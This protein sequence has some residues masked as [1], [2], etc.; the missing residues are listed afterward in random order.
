M[1]AKVGTGTLTFVKSIVYGFVS[2]ALMSCSGDFGSQ[3]FEGR[4]LLKTSSHQNHIN[5]VT[6]SKDQVSE[7]VETSLTPGDGPKDIPVNISE[8]MLGSTLKVQA[9]TFEN[10][11]TLKVSKSDTLALDQDISILD[12]GSQLKMNDSSVFVD[13]LKNPDQN[14]SPELKA[15]MV[16]KFRI[17]STTN[18]GLSLSN[19]NKQYVVVYKN[20]DKYGSY[21]GV[22][23]KN[24]IEY[25]GDYVQFEIRKFGS[26]QL[27]KAGN[28]FYQ[29]VEH[30]VSGSQSTDFSATD[31]S[32]SA[33]VDTE[34][35]HAG[36]SNSNA[37]SGSKSSEMSQSQGNDPKNPK[38][39]PT[40]NSPESVKLSFTNLD[41][42][43]SDTQ[44]QYVEI[45]S[46]S[47]D[48]CL[49]LPLTRQLKEGESSYL[50]FANCDQRAGQ[51]FRL[52]HRGGSIFSIK[53]DQETCVDIS[54]GSTF[55]MIPALGYGCHY[56][57]NQTFQL[58]AEGD[59]AD[60]FK[61]MALHSEMC[62]QDQASAMVQFNEEQKR[63]RDDQDRDE[64]EDDDDD[65]D[66]RVE[67]DGFLQ[68]TCQGQNA[69]QQFELSVSKN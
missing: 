46:V 65:E 29:S 50:T 62:L 3:Q 18:E 33:V 30:V 66:D 31:A 61:F 34:V 48:K 12:L 58:S 67:Y 14:E 68:N 40:E 45:K 41:T 27:A 35:G 37:E 23:G 28:G 43:L 44:E 21:V 9:N 22:I 20:Y 8:E 51:K 52:F 64:R 25:H 55:R 16:A 13:Y 5:S 36:K 32:D 7:K 38:T 47:M 56:D 57:G 17:S 11:V 6:G 39:T 59:G 63:Q 24:E 54:G 15:P 1:I 10:P 19:P 53:T 69:G 2:M 49:T 60:K 4:S 26:Y 42:F